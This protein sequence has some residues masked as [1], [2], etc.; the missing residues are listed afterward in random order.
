LNHLLS[1]DFDDPL[2]S[3]QGSSV[4]PG[5]VPAP[6]PRIRPDYIIALRDLR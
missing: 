2:G 5:C 4:G 3:A 6:V 1:N